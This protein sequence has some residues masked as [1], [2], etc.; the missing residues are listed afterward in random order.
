MANCQLALS[1][2]LSLSSNILIKAFSE[3]V[4][5]LNIIRVLL[6]FGLNYSEYN[7]YLIIRVGN[8]GI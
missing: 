8:C 4:D 6:R 5:N 3:S 1:F 2:K 7:H